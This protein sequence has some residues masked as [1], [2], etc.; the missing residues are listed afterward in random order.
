LV[1][2]FHDHSFW[3]R[4]ERASGVAT[5]TIAIN[6]NATTP[7]AARRRTHPFIAG[8]LHTEP[9]NSVGVPRPDRD[10]SLPG[11]VPVMC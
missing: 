9:P 8:S 7:K 10:Q 1:T 11:V 2:G 3:H 6:A 4:D 5:A